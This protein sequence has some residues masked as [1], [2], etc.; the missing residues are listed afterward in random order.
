[1][2]IIMKIHNKLYNLSKIKFIFAIL[3]LT[4][5]ALIPLIPIH[6]LYENHI[7]PMGGFQENNKIICFLA[8]VIIAPILETLIHQ[9]GVIA[10]FSNIGK[11]KDKK[12][13]LIIISAITFGL[14][15]FYSAIYILD[16]FIIGILLA[17]SFIVYEHKG[18]SGFWVT[19]IIHS[20]RNL[21][22]FLA[23]LAL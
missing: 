9:C 22:A 19:A 2:N 20:L 17:Y 10:L 6:I 16:T 15:H 7:G 1:M 8:V 14:G 12:L 5:L 11:F 4:Y 13:V 21:I 23:T 3:A 18:Q